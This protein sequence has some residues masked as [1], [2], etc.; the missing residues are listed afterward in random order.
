MSC[1]EKQRLSD[2]YKNPTAAAVATLKAHAA[3]TSKHEYAELRHVSEMARVRADD[4]W[5]ALEQHISQHHC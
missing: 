3:T 2:R 5:L 1:L 4:A